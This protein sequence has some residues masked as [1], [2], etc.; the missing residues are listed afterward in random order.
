MITLEGLVG[1]G[2]VKPT[3]SGVES[4]FTRLMHTEVT[5]TLKRTFGRFRYRWNL[6]VEF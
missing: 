2:K 4:R 1:C 6:G 5:A 3:V